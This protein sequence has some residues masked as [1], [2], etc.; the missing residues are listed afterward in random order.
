M[1]FTHLTHRRVSLSRQRIK[2]TGNK[3]V[4]KEIPHGGLFYRLRKALL[5]DVVLNLLDDS[6]LHDATVKYKGVLWQ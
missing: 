4:R 2:S 6:L 1:M 3:T 5:H